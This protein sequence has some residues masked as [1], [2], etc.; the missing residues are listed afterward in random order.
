MA[1]ELTGAMRY[2][3]IN[4]QTLSAL[5]VSFYGSISKKES[6]ILKVAVI[7]DD[8]PLAEEAAELTR[9]FFGEKGEDVF[10]EIYEKGSSLIYNLEKD[11]R[12]ELYLLDLRLSDYDGAELLERIREFQSDAHVIVI[13][14]Y[15]EYLLP[16][17]HVGIFDF[18]PKAEMKSTLS[19]A[20]KRVWDIV[21]N[22]RRRCYY[23]QTIGNCHKIPLDHIFYIEIVSRAAV[24]HCTERQYTEYR[25]LKNI[26]EDLPEGEFAFINS[27]QIVNLWRVARVQG[28]EIR[29]DDGTELRCSRRMKKEFNQKVLRFLG[30]QG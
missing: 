15:P 12:Y 30:R 11:T 6:Q 18:I 17:V 5:T 26:Y 21:Q 23:I 9:R 27:G 25:S 20:L 24:F 29:M 8:A 2:V 10:V 19:Q 4:N 28:D 3:I 22:E 13:S 16:C 7:D 1:V 14:S